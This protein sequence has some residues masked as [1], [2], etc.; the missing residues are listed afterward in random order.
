MIHIRQ[1]NSTHGVYTIVNTDNW[2]LPI[3]QHPSV[4]EHPDIFEVVDEDIP[5]NHQILNYV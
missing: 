2:I 3:D 1:K 4:V 5:E